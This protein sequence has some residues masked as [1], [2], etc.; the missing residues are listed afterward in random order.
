[1]AVVGNMT[2]IKLLNG[3]TYNIRD[4]SKVSKVANATSGNFAGLDSNGDLTDSGSKASDFLTSHQDISG[5]ADK[6]TSATS[7]N[8]A[9]LDSNGNLTDS[10]SK[11]SDFLTSH[12]DISGKADKTD[13]VLETTLSRGR[14]AN[15]TV[16]TGSFAFGN[17][18]TASG[19]Y[20][21]AEGYSTNASGSYAHAE[22]GLT[23]AKI[24][25]HAE[26]YTTK[27][28]G[29]CSHSE[30]QYTTAQ[31]RSQHAGGE[32]NVPDTTG[33]SNTRGDYVEIIGNG[34]SSS[35]LSNARTLD[36]SGNERLNGDL[37][38][39]CNDDSTGGTKVIAT[40][41]TGATSSTA[42]AIGLVPAPAA[43]DE[44]KYLRGDGTWVESGIANKADKSATVLSTTL[45]RGRKA[46]TTI[47][48][49]SFAFGNDITASGTYSHAEGTGT[50]ASN[51]GAHAEGE[52]TTAS[53]YYS[54]AEGSGST[55]SAICSH[56]EGLSTVA[57]ASE[58]HAE[59]YYTIAQRINQHVSG[60]YNVADTT[61]A[62]T[63]SLGKFAEIV[64]NGDSVSNRS[65][66]R[67]LDW[68]GNEY[69]MGDLYIGCNADST[70]GTKI[71]PSLKPSSPIA[72]PMAGTSVIYTMTGLT[73]DHYVSLWN[74]S[75]SAENSPPASITITTATNQFT[76]TNNGGNT[77]ETVQPLFSTA[78]AVTCTA[79]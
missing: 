37:Y 62:T 14:K 40:A 49:G 3:D 6:V 69:L 73:A 42:G 13:T 58:S 65:N 57:S 67:A 7:G 74:F 55:A 11:A 64:G 36:W 15:T 10:G 75:L 34:T 78:S 56:A 44:E 25:A 29:D 66:A 50:T 38:I 26:G 41:F 35:S 59:G 12:Q 23:Q 68:S 33:T 51:N 18:V 63:S 24:Y 54:H 5:K 17:T 79:Q 22:G 47:G 61:G 1:M 76:I 27:A 60:A 43:G 46:N 20:A 71:S 8:F 45:S 72:I 77:S 4:D 31:C 21:H 2:A 19:I 16:G 32:Y 48:I 30:G 52:M 53:G 39:N 28:M 70:G 9:G